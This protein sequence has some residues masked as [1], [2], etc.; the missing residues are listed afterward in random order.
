[1]NTSK[2]NIK[3]RENSLLENMNRL[4]EEFKE[5]SKPAVNPQIQDVIFVSGVGYKTVR[6]SVERELQKIN[7]QPQ[8]LTPHQQ[9]TSQG[10]KAK[11]V[12][13]PSAASP[14]SYRDLVQMKAPDEQHRMTYSPPI[15]MRGEIERKPSLMKCS[16]TNSKGAD[17]SPQTRKR[18]NTDITNAEGA[19]TFVNQ[20]A[21]DQMIP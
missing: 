20:T 12:G 19:Q 3:S 11:E 4:E 5:D 9:H 8:R 18:L 16:T 10:R 17:S 7:E 21:H 15:V 2:L 1:M 6:S 14:N 13:S